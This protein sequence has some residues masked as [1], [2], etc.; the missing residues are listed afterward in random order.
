MGGNIVHD[1]AGRVGRQTV[2]AAPCR[3]RTADVPEAAGPA[4][5]IARLPGVEAAALDGVAGVVA[6]DAD[7]IVQHGKIGLVGLVPV[8][9]AA[10]LPRLAVHQDILPAG[11]RIQRGAHGVDG[12]HIVQAHQVEPEA[13]DVVF[14]RPVEDGIDHIPPGHGP[15]AGKFVAAAAAVGKAAVL[16]LAEK[17]AG[18]GVV[19]RVLIAVHVVIHHIHHHTDARRVQGCDHFP[20]LPDAHLAAGGVGG[21]AA[22]GHIVVGGVIAPVVL[23][24]QRLCLVYAA[25]VEN[26]HQLHILHAQTP[27]VVQAGGVDAVP[28]QGGALLGK[29][30][31]LAP[32]CRAHAAGSILRE[33]AHAHLPH[34]A[35]LRWDDRTHIPLPPGG[36]GAGKVHDHAA[37]AVHACRTG[38]GVAGLARN[39]IHC[40]RIGIVSSVLVAGQIDAPH[41]LLPPLQ[42]QSAYGLTAAAFAVKADLHPLRRGCPQ[43]QMGA[44]NSIF[45]PQRAGVGGLKVKG[46]AL[47]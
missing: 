18:H 36:G 5:H 10:A 17:V 46:D 34:C 28:V 39:A 23:P 19:Q 45:L 26:R 41:P 44:G 35:L 16:V 9:L 42:R 29:G 32:P 47:V 8:Q 27:E 30:H 15:L 24:Q 43:A 12:L 4:L 40:D 14:L 2:T 13:V 7:A 1:L 21:I 3:Y 31:E 22:L 37:G 20:A 25:K 33:V 38:I 11:Q 6:E